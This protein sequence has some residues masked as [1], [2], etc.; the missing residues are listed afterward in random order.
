LHYNNASTTMT[1]YTLVWIYGGAFLSGDAHGNVGTADVLGQSCRMDVWIPDYRKAPSHGMDDISDD[2]AAAY[3]WVREKRIKAGLDPSKIVLAGWSAG[4]ALCTRLMQSLV[5]DRQ[6]Q[7]S[8]PK[9]A[10]L[11]SPF[12]QYERP[13]PESSMQHYSLHDWMVTR[14]I[15]DMAEQTLA[16]DTFWNHRNEHHSPLSHSMVGLP[17][18][19]V[20][21]SEHEAV[22][23]Q[24]CCLVAHARRGRVPVTTGV[25]RYMAH[26]WYMLGGLLPEGERALQFAGQFIRAQCCDDG[27]P[28]TI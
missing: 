19:C 20:I 12:V 23:E 3:Q 16:V 26:G 5:V 8:M 14:N 15:M 1:E 10:V 24:T 25:W 27:Q 17:P 21:V 28:A 4:A 18:L 9:A 6:Q 13:T 2:I 22:Y 11:F 7:A